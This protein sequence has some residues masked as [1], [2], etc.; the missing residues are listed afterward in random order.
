MRKHLC[1]GV[2]LFVIVLLVGRVEAVQI[3][4]TSCSVW[5]NPRTSDHDPSYAIDGDTVTYTWSTESFNTA[6]N[7]IGL[8]FGAFENV[9]RIRLWKDNAS[10][11]PGVTE[12]KDL[13]I[14]YT[15]DDYNTSLGD[16]SFM[17]VSGLV[18]GYN[19]IELMDEATVYSD[20]TVYHDNHDYGDG[21]ASLTFNNVV[22]TGVAIY[23]TNNHPDTYHHYKV[24]EFEAHFEPSAAVPEPTT[25][26]LLGTG[27]LCLTGTRRKMKS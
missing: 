17:N 8:D 15:V 27:M 26:L 19:G 22:A 13:T 10:G 6:P 25:L 7:Y 16:R 21:W 2:V 14:L 12:A 23:F 9:N 3:S 11:V 4:P 24:H 20:G 18:N 5:D 1:S